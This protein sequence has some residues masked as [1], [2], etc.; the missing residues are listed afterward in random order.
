MTFDYKNNPLYPDRY[1]RDKRWVRVLPVPGRPIQTAE[2]IEIQSLLSDQIKQ[3]IDTLFN[4]G[5]ILEGLKLSIVSSTDTNIEINI[6]PG[7]LYVEGYVIDIDS[8]TITLPKTGK[9]S[10]D[11]AIQELIITEDD[12][13]ILRDPIKGG[14]IYGLEGASRLMWNP[15]ITVNNSNGYTIGLLSDGNLSQNLPNTLTKIENILA[16]YT[17]E[18]SGNFCV[19]GFSI[20]SLPGESRVI[21]DRK[22]YDSLERLV[23]NTNSAAQQALSD[24][25]ASLVRLNQ[26]KASLNNAIENARIS[27]TSANNAAIVNIQDQINR[28]QTFYNRLSTL[29][30]SKLALYQTSLDNLNANKNLLVD[31]VLFSISA[32]I[33]YVQ[34]YRIAKNTPTTLVVDKSLDTTRVQNAQFTYSGRNASTKRVFSLGENYTFTDVVNQRTLITIV[35]D[36]LIYNQEFIA[37]TLTVNLAGSTITSI[38]SLLDALFNYINKGDTNT[39]FSLSSSNNTLTTQDLVTIIK[40]NLEIT[41]EATNGLVFRSTSI[42][43]SAN[44]ISIAT[45]IKQRNSSNV[46]IGDSLALLIDVAN[47]NLSGGGS[48]NSFQLGF[49]PV[50]EIISLVAE[51]EEVLKPIVRSSTP[52]TSDFLGDDSIFRITKVVQGSTTYIEGRDY[53]LINQSEID[54]SLSL[55]NSIEP[56]PG[57]TYFVSFLYTQPLVIDKD[58]TLDKSTDSI[59]FIGT[60]PATNQNFTVSYSYYL[61]K[62]GVIYITKEGDIKYQL[63]SSSSSP[64]PPIVSEEVLSIATFKLFADSTSITPTDCRA[65]SFSEISQLANRVKKN[66]NDIELLSLDIQGYRKA[67]QTISTSPIGIYTNTLQDLSRINLSNVL[68]TGTLSP[69]TQ[70]ITNGYFHKDVPLKYVSGGT[71]S[72]DSLGK[73]YF[74]VLP[75]VSSAVLSQVRS[76]NSTKINTLTH[77]KQRGRVFI[78]PN[79]SFLNEGYKYLSPCDAITNRTNLLSRTSTNRPLILDSISNTVRSLF[80]TASEEIVKSIIDGCPISTFSNDPNSYLYL[81]ST[82]S[83]VKPILVTVKVDNLVPSSEGYKVY[84]SGKEITNYTLTNST[85]SS[86][87]FPGT[88][89]AKVD[90]SIHFTFTTPTDL[91]CGSHLLEIESSDYYASGLLNV[92]NNL[93]TQIVLAAI[94]NWDTVPSRIRANSLI[95]LD[96]TDYSDILPT[97]PSNTLVNSGT[98]PS[99]EIISLTKSQKNPKLHDV[100]NQT[101]DLKDYYFIT[102]IKLKIR[103]INTTNPLL[104]KLKGASD[105]G[106]NK[107]LYGI[108]K[109]S[110]Y[111]VTDNASSWTTFTFDYPI[112]IQ[113]NNKY[114]ISLES[115]G[116]GYEVYTAEIGSKDIIT[117]SIVGDQ[118]FLNG[119][120]FISTD[121]YSYK[122]LPKEDIT[123]ELYRA[124]FTTI[125]EVVVDLGRY[126][127]PDSMSGLSAFSINTRDILPI[128]TNIEYQYKTTSSDWITIIPNNVVCLSTSSTYI[129]VRAKLSSSKANV[130]PILVIQGSSVSLYLNNLS[131]SIV[132]KQTIYPVPYKNVVVNIQYIQPAN[133]TIKVY[134]SPTDGLPIEGQEWFELTKDVA[135]EK[136][137]DQGLGVLEANYKIENS[138]LY[139]NNVL[140]RIKF[141]YRVDISSTVINNQPVIRNIISYVY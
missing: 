131:S 93:A 107:D 122:K 102:S 13:P 55:A 9:Y 12:D 20:T 65:V 138:S 23:D 111:Q 66:T 78:S 1:S 81:L 129:D 50:A 99:T 76:T 10:I 109:A 70:G 37:V 106:P 60:T 90:G 45:A 62:A 63:S 4:N 16:Q 43:N 112:L 7:K 136:Y 114:S 15:V 101:I 98:V 21:E 140:P 39:V 28:E 25:N 88:I 49:K 17:Y 130:S 83:K 87:R 72:L 127:S 48:F 89:K 134:Y 46:V 32:G 117:S 135:S 95:P 75:Y 113:P 31:K 8:N 6:S 116:E 97:V 80:K 11:V 126:G 29:Y 30:S 77:V 41:R 82:L 64:I 44:Q 79:I 137:I 24:S 120:L 74:I 128:D 132:S 85:A 47:S 84:L 123:F 3:G 121:G 2:L 110:S 104:V 100:V 54:W 34:G 141:R 26:L 52:G 92:F 58:F 57:T 125:N 51:L 96:K 108:A 36:K 94:S 42:A 22:K 35:I 105:E 5:S 61:A 33:A 73:D 119:D 103:K 115:I 71:K 53:I 69:A 68:S 19:N 67:V 124:V 118:L 139:I 40:S 14:A 91:R 86:I 133:T 38:S 27:P 56:D 18:R 59:R